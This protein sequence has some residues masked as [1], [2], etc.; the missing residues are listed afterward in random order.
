MSTKETMHC[1]FNINQVFLSLV[2]RQG[3][4]KLSQASPVLQMRGIAWQLVPSTQ[5]LCKK[6]KGT[7]LKMPE[8]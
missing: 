2:T 5:K 1:R 4:A 7:L 3:K 6:L 8:T